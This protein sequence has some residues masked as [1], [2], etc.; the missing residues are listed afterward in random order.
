MDV[1][2]E[3]KRK[4]DEIMMTYPHMFPYE[5]VVNWRVN[6]RDLIG[7]YNGV[8][9]SAKYAVPVDFKNQITDEYE[10][11]LMKY[12]EATGRAGELKKL[13]KWARA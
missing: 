2:A 13:P 9:S 7:K 6:I 10:R 12:Y 1:P 4:L 11:R 5:I 3:E 8:L